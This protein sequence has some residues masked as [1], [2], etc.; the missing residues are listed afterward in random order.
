MYGSGSRASLQAGASAETSLSVVDIGNIPDAEGVLLRNALID[1]FYQGGYPA[2]PRYNLSFIRIEE[3]STRLDL[4]S[5]SETTRSQ[6]RQRT[7][8]TLTDRTTGK[9]VLNRELFSV[10]SY[11][12][13]E[14]EFATRA[15]EQAAR[16]SAI[17]DLA[18]Q[19]ELQISLFL[20]REAAASGTK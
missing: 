8:F 19:T 11:N 2:A 15:S 4:T 10:S 9:A 17:E 20:N 13:L 7:E 16:E 12:I 14:S 18:R 1:R 3:T 5:D 6:L